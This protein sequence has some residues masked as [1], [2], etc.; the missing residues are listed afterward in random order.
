MITTVK[1]AYLIISK[2]LTLF[3]FYFSSNLQTGSGA[4]PASYTIGIGGPFP[5]PKRGRSL[6]LPT[7]SHLVPRSRMNRSYTS[8]SPKRQH[9]V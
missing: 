9:F 3:Y 7:H 5:G 8:S 1:I 6:T 4:H 2:I